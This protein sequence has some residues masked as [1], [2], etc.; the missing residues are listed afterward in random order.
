[1]QKN[2]TDAQDTGRELFKREFTITGKWKDD[3]II[4]YGRLN[5]TFHEMEVE[6]RFSFPM[7][8]VLELKGKLIRYPHN[9]CFDSASYLDRLEGLKI[10]RHFYTKLME[11]TGGPFGCSHLN[12]LIYEM[13]MSAVQVRFARYD[14]I[15]PKDFE[16]LSKPQKIKAY[17]K[18]MPGIKGSCHAWAQD[19]PMVKQAE[20]L[21]E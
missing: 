7:L 4:V 19:S 5:D 12:N 18:F 21:K 16:K 6:A 13:G 14:E 11:H 2:E 9:E 10:T 17:L 3:C 1:M 8:E 15:A 20:D